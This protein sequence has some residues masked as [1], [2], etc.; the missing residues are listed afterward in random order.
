MKRTEEKTFKISN[1]I[2]NDEKSAP[3]TQNFRLQ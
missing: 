2:A 1:G 3:K